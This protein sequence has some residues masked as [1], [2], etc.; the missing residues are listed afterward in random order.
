MIW[1]RRLE[2]ENCALRK[3][4]AEI[5]RMPKS[6]EWKVAIACALKQGISALNTW[7]AKELNMRVPQTV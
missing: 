6:A 1:Q 5:A 3:S 4:S 2:R 7:I